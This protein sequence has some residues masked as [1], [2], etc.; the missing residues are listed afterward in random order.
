MTPVQK[1]KTTSGHEYTVRIVS[2]D[3][4]R[5]N[6]TPDE[7]TAT[8]T[9]MGLSMESLAKALGISRQAIWRWETG[10]RPIPPYLG[11]AL[12]ALDGPTTPPVS[13][14]RS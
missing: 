3:E 4:D 12:K 10:S 8:R 6:M 7:L 1:F 9:A 2:N 13:R 14:I 11:L 5:E